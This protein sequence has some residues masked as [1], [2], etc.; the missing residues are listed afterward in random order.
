MRELIRGAG[1]HDGSAYAARESAEADD[2][3]RWAI[4]GPPVS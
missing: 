3:N 2:G 1:D 4:V